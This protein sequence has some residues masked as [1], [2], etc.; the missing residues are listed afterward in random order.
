MG[1]DT[2]IRTTHND[3]GGRAIPT[4]EVLSSNSLTLCQGSTT[5]AVD[6]QGHGTHCAGS[7]AG[8]TYGV[9]PGAKVHAVKVLNDQGYGSTSWTVAAIDWVIRS[10][11]RPAVVSMSLGGPGTS[12]A[13]KIA[14]DKATNAG[15]V[16]VVAAGNENDD[17][18]GYSPAYVPNAITVGSTGSYDR[19]S[20]FSNYGSCVQIYAPGSAIIS[21]SHL[22]DSGTSTKSGTSMACPHVAGAAALLLERNFVGMEQVKAEMLRTAKSGIS[23]LQIGDPNKLLFV[24]QGSSNPTAPTPAPSIP[25]CYDTYSG[26]QSFVQVGMC[27]SSYSWMSA[28]CRLSC[29][30]C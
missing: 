24:G 11:E 29:G 28:N 25:N 26:C 17:A 4:L 14:I 3:F 12:R 18:C 30:W 15:V 22:S 20:G 8:T 27:S 19:R 5:C 13:D 2:G 10:G 23:Q 9:A 1:L 21:A 6:V 7:A 16:V